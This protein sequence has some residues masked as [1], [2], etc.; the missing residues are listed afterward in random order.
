MNNAKLLPRIPALFLSI[1]LA[2]PSPAFALRNLEI[3]NNAAGLE[4]LETR[5]KEGQ[6]SP[7]AA[8]AEE[9]F[10][11]GGVTQVRMDPSEEVFR[12]TAAETEIVGRLINEINLRK[13]SAVGFLPDTE[14]F[15]SLNPAG[16][17]WVPL[18]ELDKDPGKAVELLALFLRSHGVNAQFEA[19]LGR[20]S[21]NKGSKGMVF[22][23]L[24]LLTP[25]Q[26]AGL[27]SP[28]RPEEGVL[29]EKLFPHL[30][31][32]GVPYSLALLALELYNPLDVRMSW[33]HESSAVSSQWRGF[34]DSPGGRH[35]KNSVNRTVHERELKL[36][37]VDFNYDL[38]IR[39]RFSA[40][41][42]GGPIGQTANITG[43]LL[44]LREEIKARR[45]ERTQKDEQLKDQEA[46]EKEKEVWFKAQGLKGRVIPEAVVDEVGRL[47]PR[48]AYGL[49][50]IFG[51]GIGTRVPLDAGPW[52]D[53]SQTA[54]S[55][56]LDDGMPV[57]F[58]I[59]PG[60]R[61]LVE[62]LLHGWIDFN[63]LFKALGNRL[64]EK[65]DSEQD[66][67]GAMALGFV[68]G[69]MQEGWQ[70]DRVFRV[71][72]LPAGWLV[73]NEGAE[74][75]QV[76]QIKPAMLLKIAQV[77]GPQ[78]DSALYWWHVDLRLS[79][80]SFGIRPLNDVL[81]ER[82]L[83]EWLTGERGIDF[84]EGKARMKENLPQVAAILSDLE[85]RTIKGKVALNAEETKGFVGRTARLL[86]L[87][88]GAEQ[89]RVVTTADLEAMDDK[90]A[91]RLAAQARKK[92]NSHVV[93]VQRS[94]ARSAQTEE[95][96]VIRLLA[97][98]YVSGPATAI[99]PLEWAVQL[100]QEFIPQDIPKGR[101]FLDRMMEQLAGSQNLVIA[102]DSQFEKN[103]PELL[104]EDHTVTLVIDPE[105]ARIFFGPDDPKEEYRK[106][107][108]VILLQPK[109]ILQ[110]LILKLSYG[111]VQHVTIQ[112][113]DYV[114]FFA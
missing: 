12:F 35:F 58:R 54:Y 64:F 101:D 95:G 2:L 1:L 110:N 90:Q 73:G 99:L 36:S 94:A 11:K 106:A 102:V 15:D 84:E 42:F 72:G 74:A 6:P 78:L 53:R 5:L 34:P 82:R 20:F 77:L 93:L 111:S 109:E 92:G 16:L 21:A 13:V 112:G 25:D 52:L 98:E 63:D 65:A 7:I 37:P 79:S 47:D 108:A 48:D 89:V 88:A 83:R 3:K 113:E 29:G 87:A 14:P 22:V 9:G 105:W 30:D 96:L 97:H 39:D 24:R 44:L 69:E 17:R 56:R 40:K 8:G 76:G 33:D 10:L 68:A 104:P 75:H 100:V 81:P 103:L 4:D 50:S 27:L 71:A 80:Q 59:T 114:A 55:Y 45:Q 66:P 18:Q 85:Q 23:R 51:N 62:Q 32:K 60:T 46:R 41:G 57:T 43:H 70:K 38:L 67:H 49:F 19:R 86:S 31:L 91:K 28:P 26:E 107:L 61:A